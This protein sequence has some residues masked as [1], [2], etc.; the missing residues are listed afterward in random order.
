[1]S[2]PRSY[3]AIRSIVA[4]EVLQT[5]VAR[6]IVRKAGVRVGV[7]GGPTGRP[8]F[9]VVRYEFFDNDIYPEGV[10]FDVQITQFSRALSRTYAPST[11]TG[12]AT[13]AVAFSTVNAQSRIWLEPFSEVRVTARV[14]TSTPNLYLIP[15]FGPL[16]GDWGNV[17]PVAKFAD[18][19]QAVRT[20]TGQMVQLTAPFSKSDWQPIHSSFLALG[21]VRAGLFIRNLGASAIS[22]QIGVCEI[23]LR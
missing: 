22:P 16:I 17:V 6:A 5:R 3:S 20:G 18:T 12:S 13:R 19:A 23:Q 7:G 11:I 9:T 1:L 8:P 10:D 15:A 2:F 14:V 21:E 4:G